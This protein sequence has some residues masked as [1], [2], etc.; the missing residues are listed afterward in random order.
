MHFR[1]RINNHDFLSQ[2][3]VTLATSAYLFWMTF[4]KEV[5]RATTQNRGTRGN[6]NHT[7]RETD[8]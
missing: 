3:V 1:S 8:W 6:E 2:W 5:M 7:F 4:S